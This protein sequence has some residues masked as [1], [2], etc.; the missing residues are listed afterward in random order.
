MAAHRGTAR[1]VGWLYIVASA[2]G[3]A[4]LAL[5]E[6]VLSSPARLGAASAHGDRLLAGGLLEL[7]MGGAAVAIAVVIYPVLKRF[8]ERQALGYLVARAVEAVIYLIGTIA[9]L[10][11]VTASRDFV[12]AGAAEASAYHAAGE[13]TMVVRDWGGHVVLDV[14]AFSASALILNT[15]LYRA[16]LV[17][18]W[19]SGWGL[20]GA[21]LYWLGGVLAMFWLDPG[22]AAQVALDVPLGIQEMVFAIWLIVKGFEGAAFVTYDAE[23]WRQEAFARRAP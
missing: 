6:P 7:I 13:L 17:P 19:L 1:T 21:G 4:G 16:R 9:L 22:S 10:T 14:T 15:V 12:E 23:G 5:E 3:V 20:V 18:R 2:A 11:L 8:G